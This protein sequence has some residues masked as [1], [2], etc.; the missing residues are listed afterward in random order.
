MVVQRGKK[1]EVFIG[2]E[3]LQSSELFQHFRRWNSL[4]KFMAQM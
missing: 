4:E 3:T 2:A 1:I